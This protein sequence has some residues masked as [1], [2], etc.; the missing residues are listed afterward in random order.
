MMDVLSP[1]QR[2]LNMSRIRGR[3]TRPEMLLRRGLHARGLRFRLHRK[4]LPGKPDLVFPRF[5][6]V[7]FVNG[8]F[9][10][11]HGCELFN[12]PKTRPDFWR[13]KIEGN[14]NRDEEQIK[15]L[16]TLGWRVLVIW[17]CAYRGKNK[18]AMVAILDE[19][20]HFIRKCDQNYLV[21]EGKKY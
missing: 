16:K 19:A 2:S 7:I 20:E 12:L 8:C 18:K 11:G 1:E 3:N 9:W 6:V 21:I 17:E 15:K 14:R 4:S 13:R 5:L 10:H